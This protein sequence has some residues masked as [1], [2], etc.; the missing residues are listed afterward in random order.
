EEVAADPSHLI[1][2]ERRRRTTFTPTGDAVFDEMARRPEAFLPDP[3]SR[4]ERAP[5]TPVPPPGDG[6]FGEMARRAEAFLVD[7]DYREKSIIAGYPWFADWGRDSMISAP[8]LAMATN[9]YGA[10]ARVLNGF[11]AVRR[12][13]LLPNNFV[14]EE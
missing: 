6:V 8:G 2:A 4:G 5:R 14:G 13:G 7:A 3:E 12:D 9:R 10:I 11:A 1:E